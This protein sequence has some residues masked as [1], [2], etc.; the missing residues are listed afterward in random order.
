MKSSGYKLLGI[1]LLYALVCGISISC[2][3]Q[4]NEEQNITADSNSDK[5]NILFNLADDV[6]QEV[7]SC[8]GGES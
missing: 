5:P 6:G 3:Q 8:Y 7:L 2:H 4:A 1:T